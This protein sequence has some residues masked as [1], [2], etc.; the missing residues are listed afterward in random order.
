MRRALL[1][2]VSGLLPLVAHADS[3]THLVGYQCDARRNELVVTYRGAWNEAGEAMLA[4]KTATE[5]DPLNLAT[6]IDDDHYGPS[7]VV[8]ARC[9]LRKAVYRVRLGASPQ[10]TRMDVRC[11]L[12]IGAWVEV[13]TGRD[14]T[15][16]RHEF[17]RSCD[18]DD[19]V[20]TRLVFRP[21][22]HEPVTTSV[23]H[24]EFFK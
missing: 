2:L 8:E 14:R 7:R 12:E 20:V 22:V 16:F 15:P 19:L 3:F 11:G 1:V 17:A 4:A 18:S 23:E 21:G 5:W 13:A 24:D 9:I 10:N 6:A